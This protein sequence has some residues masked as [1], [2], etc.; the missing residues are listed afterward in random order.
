[1]DQWICRQ[2][3]QCPDSP[4]ILPH[5]ANSRK[6]HQTAEH[7]ELEFSCRFPYSSENDTL[8]I[9][10]YYE[11]RPRNHLAD[12]HPNHS[13]GLVGLVPLKPPIRPPRLSFDCHLKDFASSMNNSCCHDVRWHLERRHGKT[14]EGS[15]GTCSSFEKGDGQ[16]R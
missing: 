15:V 11:I 6:R 12:V 5:D 16:E 7:Y 9:E 2:C 13:A 10:Y 1:M 8:Q 4:N 14:E 3:V